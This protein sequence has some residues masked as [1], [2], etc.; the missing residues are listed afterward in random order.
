MSPLFKNVGLAALA[1]FI[2][3]FYAFTSAVPDS[4]VTSNAVKAAVVSALY[5][6][7]RA[8]VAKLH[9]AVKGDPFKVDT[10]A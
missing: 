6:A 1:A 7:G 3:T 5:A 4:G 2:T 10:E 9:E 8:A